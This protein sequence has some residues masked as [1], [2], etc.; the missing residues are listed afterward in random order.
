MEWRPIETAPKDGTDIIALSRSGYVE[1]VK[2]YDNPF[3][4]KDTVINTATGKWWTA[5][6]WIPLPPPPTPASL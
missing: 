5:V 2:W 6:G 1:R 3:G 4:N